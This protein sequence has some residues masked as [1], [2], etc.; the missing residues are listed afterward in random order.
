MERV[1]ISEVTIKE[2]AKSRDFSL[3]F[4][5]KIE[6]SKL[7][8][9]L[10]VSVIELDEIKSKKVDSLLVKS[11]ASAV[12][13]S[14]VAVPVDLV[15][16]KIEMTWE[17]LKGAR[18]PRLQV[19]APVSTV[20]ME[21]I[22]HMKPEMILETI[23]NTVSKCTKYCGEVEFIADDASRSEKTFL[24]DA[25]STAIDAG[26]SIVTI[27]DTAGTMLPD[28][29]E[30][31]ILDIKE[32]VPSISRVRLGV[33]CADEIAMAD[34]CAIAA[35]KAGVREIKAASYDVN[36]ISVENLAKVVST[37][38][39]VIGVESDIRYTEINRIM[40]QI[41]WICETN[42][43]VHSPFDMGVRDVE[44]E[45]FILSV[46]DSQAAVSKVA[47]SMGYE[48]SEDDEAKVYEAFQ[49]I[50]VKKGSVG[51]KE[52]D[53][54]VASVAMQVPPTYTVHSYVINT[55]NIITAMAHLKLTKDGEELEGISVGDG[56]IDAA[57]LAIENIIGTHYELDD[58]QIQAVTQGREAMGETVVKLRSNG[59]VYSGHG[60]ST[61]IVG[62]SIRAYVN[63]LNKIVYEEA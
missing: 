12:R 14:V 1:Y 17:V 37:K 41:K 45:S 6:L 59:R 52:L 54:I 23:K 20:Q 15:G 36:S 19:H 44:E 38:G 7:Y 40:S 56:P 13:N 46:H 8:D 22:S 60:I 10:D 18:F 16:E 48:L 11:I 33:A 63:A 24:A 29:F 32:S 31:F 5:E 35:I 30:K 3:S 26:A 25:I 61:D 53:S 55:G 51:R 28:E 62:A 21:Y 57:F 49:R 2:V 47:K 43:S 27:C 34:S 58:F 4:K 9:K 50:A 42:R 39:H